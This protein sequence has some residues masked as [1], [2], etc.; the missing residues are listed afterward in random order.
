MT[1]AAAA[2]SPSERQRPT[3]YCGCCI[4]HQVVWCPGCFGFTGCDTCLGTYQV[5]CPVCAGGTLEPIRW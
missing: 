4:G 5:P 3:T 1:A 2:R